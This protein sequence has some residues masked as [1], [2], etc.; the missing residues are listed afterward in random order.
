MNSGCTK[1]YP[2][3]RDEQTF[4]RI[5]DYPYS[6]WR[7]RRRR[8]ERVVE[9]AIDYSVPNITEFVTR[10]VRMQGSQELGTLAL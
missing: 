3:P 7:A 5:P 1:P 4:Q 9:L 8:G 10:I 6:Y 2:H